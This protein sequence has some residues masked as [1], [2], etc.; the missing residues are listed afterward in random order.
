MVQV[1]DNQYR[2]VGNQVFIIISSALALFLTF[3]SKKLVDYLF[4]QSK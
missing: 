3:K 1:I 4:F 2:I